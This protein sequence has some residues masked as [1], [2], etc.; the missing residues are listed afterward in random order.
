MKSGI[1]IDCGIQGPEITKRSVAIF[2]NIRGPAITEFI[3]AIAWGIQRP[4]I[5]RFSATS[6]QKII[7]TCLKCPILLVCLGT[8]G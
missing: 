7:K 3:V 8:W 5:I 6:I 1:A 4:A 2:C